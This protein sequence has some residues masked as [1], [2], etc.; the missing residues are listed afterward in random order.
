MILIAGMGKYPQCLAGCC[1]AWRKLPGPGLI[2]R[3]IQKSKGHKVIGIPHNGYP[4]TYHSAEQYP[5]AIGKPALLKNSRPQRKHIDKSQG[6][7]VFTGLVNSQGLTGIF[8]CGGQIACFHTAVCQEGRAFSL[9]T[10]APAIV[11]FCIDPVLPACVEQ[12]LI[13]QAGFFV[14]KRKLFVRFG[15]KDPAVRSL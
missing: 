9:L 10:M 2:S 1:A 8:F 5:G 4:L 6:S 7:A 11:Q 13:M 15:F 3:C 12:H 14:A